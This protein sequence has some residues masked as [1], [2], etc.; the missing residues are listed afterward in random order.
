MDEVSTDPNGP[1][2][3]PGRNVIKISNAS[4]V[5]TD[6]VVGAPTRQAQSAKVLNNGQ[7]VIY[8]NDRQY[9]AVGQ[10]IR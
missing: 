7:L 1:A 4:E 10:E 2:Y 3:I 5:A 9:N 6:I 8:N